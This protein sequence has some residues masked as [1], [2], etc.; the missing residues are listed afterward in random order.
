MGWN[1]TS[2]RLSGKAMKSML[3]VG[4]AASQRWQRTLTGEVTPLA[5]CGFNACIQAIR[6]SLPC[7]NPLTI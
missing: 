7:R 4:G 1:S 2:G 5:A 3:S 6:A